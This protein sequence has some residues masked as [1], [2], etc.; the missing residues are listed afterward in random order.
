MKL[1]FLLVFSLALFSSQLSAQ[2][3]GIKYEKRTD[4]LNAKDCKASETYLKKKIK[5][6]L[7]AAYTDYPDIAVDF[8]S[9]KGQNGYADKVKPGRFVYPYKIEM[10]VFLRRKINKEGKELTELTTWKYDAVYE[11]ATLKGGN[12]EFYKLP[13]S[14]ITR[15]NHQEF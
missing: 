1:P 7:A 5:A 8:K 4:W 9:F 14:Q 2:T 12:C 10:L 6:Q 15:T 11:Y 13:S 3:T